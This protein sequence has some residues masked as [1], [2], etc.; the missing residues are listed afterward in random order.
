MTALNT[1]SAAAL[2]RTWSQ[3][4][5]LP[6][7]LFI[8][9]TRSFLSGWNK[10]KVAFPFSKRK[11]SWGLTYLEFDNGS[12]GGLLNV[13][14]MA[15]L[16]VPGM[17]GKV[18]PFWGA[19]DFFAPNFCLPWYGLA[20]NGY[21]S[22][23]IL[24]GLQR[25]IVESV[26]CTLYFLTVWWLDAQVMRLSLPPRN[27]AH[28]K[29]QRRAADQGRF[30]EKTNNQEWEWG[31]KHKRFLEENKRRE[32]VMVGSVLGVCRRTTIPPSKTHPREKR[33]RP[34]KWPTHF[35][36]QCCGV[37]VQTGFIDFCT[38]L[39]FCPILPVFLSWSGRLSSA[40]F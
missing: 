30:S 20:R 33:R 22:S 34:K 5:T 16:G 38:Q 1:T 32:K 6:L 8:H 15:V 13:R 19:R 2:Q 11:S 31:Q 4:L 27:A 24:I 26:L 23:K 37:G 25:S 10:T 3:S 21:I 18:Q 29:V 28:A 36:K 35:T 7:L 12:Q 17:P 40:L 9:P 39:C 14:I